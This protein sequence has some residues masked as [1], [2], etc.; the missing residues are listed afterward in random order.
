MNHP[1]RTAAALALAA[2]I[3]TVCLL[4][5]ARL[6]LEA[7]ASGPAALL[8]AVAPAPV[9]R[10]VWHTGV[11]ATLGM[12]LSALLG[13]G[14]A[15]LT[16]LTDLR[17]RTALGFAF[18]LLLAV[19]NQVTAFAWIEFLGPAS[20]VLRPL[21]LAPP[22]GTAHPLF[23]P[24]GIAFLFGLEQAPLVF[25]V[26]RAA[27]RA[28]PAERIEAARGAG[29]GRLRAVTDIVLPAVAPSLAAGAVLAW[30]ANAGNFGTAALLG[31]PGRYPV[32]STLI[33]QRLSGFGPD[34]LGSVAALS[35]LLLAMAGIGVAAAGSA[36]PVRQEAGRPAILPLGRAR[37]GIEAGC[38]FGMAVLL[39]LPLAALAGT[40]L[41]RAY[42]VPLG[43]ANVTLGNFA[44]LMQGAG[45]VGDALLHSLLLA[46]GSAALLGLLARPAAWLARDARPLRA[47][48][49]LTG[50]PY[51]LPGTVLAV[52]CILAYLRPVFG[53]DLYDGLGILLLAYLARFFSLLH[54][55]VA[56]ALGGLDPAL[57]EAGRLA[58]AGAWRRYRDIVAP[59]L[60]PTAFA[61]ALLVFLSAFNELT[62]SALLAGAQSRTIGVALFAYEQAGEVPLAAALAFVC[63]LLTIL[64]LAAASRL[65]VPWRT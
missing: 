39:G 4:P 46:G 18:V 12:L 2:L 38:W 50:L 49:S 11:V 62:L 42:G 57:E 9:W 8:A 65:P 31:I 47:V 43:M 60:R 27:L 54:R 29:A 58:G 16:G 7:A 10:A 64:L 28:V 24:G 21:G 25:I 32:L 44:A 17:G 36:A 3:G 14:F 6:L 35:M 26:L 20:P 41:V 45:A 5:L 19:P 63:A 34:E 15:L 56:A 30:V 59:A 22:P 23:G 40:A 51:A 33:Y 52:G 48:L 61:G 53:I 55:P 13:G 1:G 37:A